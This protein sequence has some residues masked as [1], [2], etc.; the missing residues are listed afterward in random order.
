MTAPVLWNSI[1][2]DLKQSVLQLL[3]EISRLIYFNHILVNWSC[4]DSMFCDSDMEHCVTFG[5]LN[6]LH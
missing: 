6:T 3:R 4:D 1:D 2:D 5:V